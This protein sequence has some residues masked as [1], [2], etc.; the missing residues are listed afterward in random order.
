MANLFILMANLLS[1]LINNA[2]SMETLKGIRLNKWCPS[3]SHLFFFSDDAIFFL[4]G[5]VRECQNLSNIL[6]QLCVAT[7]QAI[8][9]NKSGI[10]FGKACPVSLQ[11]NMAS[12]LRVPILQQ[13]GKHLGIPS[14]WGRSKKDMFSWVMGRVNKKLEGWKESLL[15]KGG[16]EILLKTVV[17][18]VPQYAMSIFKLP[19]SICRSI[20]KRIARFW[21]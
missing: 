6:H 14:D 10:F 20:E 7:G 8:N 17:Q 3:L 18:A 2:I 21:W 16:K 11:Q 9:R 19:A 4:D 12:E 1:V 5:T 13:S 15:S